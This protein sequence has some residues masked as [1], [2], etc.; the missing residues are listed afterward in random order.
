[1]RCIAHW[2]Y[3][4]TTRIKTPSVA[5]VPDS[6][7]L[8]EYIPLQ[9]GLRQNDFFHNLFFFTHWVYSIT[10]R[11]KT[12]LFL[13]LALLSEAHWVYS[14]TTRIKTHFRIFLISL[15]Q[16]LIEYI[17][18]QQGLRPCIFQL[19]EIVPPHWVYSITT[20]IKT[21]WHNI[22]TLSN[23]SAQLELRLSLGF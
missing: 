10:T 8:I 11:I 6:S 13:V 5:Y 7:G 22:C 19:H 21:I 1:M 4:I 14:I 17:P 3:S 16:N 9:Q 23:K 18:L 20:R 12:V 15:F 2:V